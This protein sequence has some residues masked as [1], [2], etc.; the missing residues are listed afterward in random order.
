MAGP[1]PIADPAPLDGALPQSVVDGAG[2]RMLSVYLHVPFCRVRCG[3]CDFNT[4]TA[5]ELRG[6]KQSDY[7][8]EAAAEEVFAGE[9]LRATGLPERQAGTVFF[10]GGTP[11]PSTPTTSRHLPMPGSRAS[12]S[13]CSPLFRTYSRRWNGHTTPTAFL[14]SWSGRDARGSR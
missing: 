5:T 7:A 13:V 6:A 3:Y 11:T 1:Q 4:Y 9:T 2:E 12:R 8:E 14:S 10:G